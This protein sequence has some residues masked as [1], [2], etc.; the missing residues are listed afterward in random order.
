MANLSG[1]MSQSSFS[2]GKVVINIVF[3]IVCA[4]SIYP[5]LVILGTSFQNENDIIIYGYS[6]IPKNFSLTA[7]Q[8]ILQDPKVL[9]NSYMITIVT[10]V[11]GT[12]AGMWVI[13]SYAF[14]LSRKDYPYRNFLSFYVFFTMLFNGGMVPSYILMVW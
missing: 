1:S 3:V 2:M 4:A 11:L 14:A 5:F 6:I 8:M 10:T 12:L 9:V 7:Y 13:T